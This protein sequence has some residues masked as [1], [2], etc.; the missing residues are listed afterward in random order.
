M[1]CSAERF[2]C[3]W[4]TGEVLVGM[5]NRKQI[6]CCFHSSLESWLFQYLMRSATK[7]NR[8]QKDKF[9]RRYEGINYINIL[10]NVGN[11]RFWARNPCSGCSCESLRR[12]DGFSSHIRA[13]NRAAAWMYSNRVSEGMEQL[14][15]GIEDQREVLLLSLPQSSYE[16]SLIFEFAK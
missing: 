11:E 1:N 6:A 4:K 2:S 15:S 5:S 13:T 16:V 7:R 10:F 12:G 9:W 8:F 3:C 14:C